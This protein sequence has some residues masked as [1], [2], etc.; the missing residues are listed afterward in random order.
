MNKKLSKQQLKLLYSFQTNSVTNAILCV[1]ITKYIKEIQNKKILLR[2]AKE[3]MAHTYIWQQYTKK[4]AKP[5][6]LKIF[7]YQVISFLL[8]YTFTIK[9]LERSEFKGKQELNKLKEK[10]PEVSYIIS[11]KET[12]K[13]DLINLLNEDRLNY[14]GAMVLGLNDALIELT[15]TISGLTFVLMNTK[16]T[17]L[18]GIITGVAAT[19]SM[20]SS[21]YLAEKTNDNKKA[22][23]SACYTGI[24]Y[25]ITVILLI[26]PYLLFPKDMFFCAFCSM[27]F[28][29][30]FL[31][32]TFSA[33][34]SI[35][36]SEPV[37]IR[38]FEMAIISLSVTL[39]S[40]FIGLI[41]KTFFNIYQ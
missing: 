5:N 21:C 29:V 25:L 33:Y 13:K 41:A 1:K 24:A 23:I 30:I 14:I 12:H 18:A 15:G 27:L 36:K 28:L 22:V 2:I 10:Y 39:I 19:L 8:G 9:L 38:F 20:T 31:I 4:E 16:L 26:S 17:A 32:F 3:E 35:I 34:I 7:F 6:F 40:F 11:Q 37:K